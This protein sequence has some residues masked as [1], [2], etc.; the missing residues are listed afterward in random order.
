MVQ[1]LKKAIELI[2]KALVK[3]WVEDLVIAKTF[4]GFC[5][6]E[7]ILR[8]VSSLK[9]EPYK[10]AT[11][12]EESKG[13]DGYIGSTPVSI[14]PITY[15]VKKALPESIDVKMIYYDKVKDGIKV[16]FDF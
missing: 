5:F 14:K 4:V 9:K 6:Q 10:M 1:N 15:Q 7:S 16:E 3:K 2:D 13:I 8:K 11:P 12:A